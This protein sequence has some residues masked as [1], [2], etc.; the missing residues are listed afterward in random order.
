MGI[1]D[2][3]VSTSIAK[4]AFQKVN[5]P[6]CIGDG[7]EVQWSPVFENNPKIARSP[8][9]GC[10]WLHC[11]KGHRPYIA[12]RTP[13]RFV[14][15]PDFKAEPGEIYFSDAERK[16]WPEYDYPF[17]LIEPNVKNVPFSKN[18]AWPIERW[19]AVVDEL[20]DYRFVQMKTGKHKL[21]GV[22]LVGSPGIRHGFAMVARAALFL[23]TDG[24]LHHAA[25][26][27]GKPAVV[28]W[29]GLAS[30]KNLGYD[31]HVNLHAGSKPCGTLM[32]C[33]HCKYEMEKIT[34]E[35]VVAAVRKEYERVRS[36]IVEGRSEGRSVI[37][38]TGH[39]AEVQQA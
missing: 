9:P 4:R 21:Q 14:Y 15:K 37:A 8:Y 35:M 3:I 20:K 39:Q 1:G 10:L 23:G 38:E 19:Q 36:G 31:S 7:S 33:L 22:S 24:A 6:V 11:Y 27:L 32:P 34:V 2:D 17:I 12:D 25:A 5:A 29:G 16:L 30:P 13:E 18:K 26:A 28:L